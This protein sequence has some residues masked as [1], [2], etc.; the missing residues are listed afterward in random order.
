MSRCLIFGLLLISVI[1]AGCANKEDTSRLDA[2]IELTKKQISE[3]E[4][5]LKKYGEGAPLQALVALRLSLYKQTLAML[6][7]K[8]ASYL[9]YFKTS[10]QVNGNTYRPPQDLAERLPKIEENLKNARSELDTA[11]KKAAEARGLIAALAFLDAETKALTVAQLEY[12]L[13][14]YQNGFP[15]Y[16]AP[17]EGKIPEAEI[18]KYSA[19]SIDTPKQPELTATTPTKE[20][21]EEEM[22]KS[23]IDIRLLRKKYIP[24]DYRN[25][26]YDDVVSI[27]LEY[28]NKT[29]REIRAFTGLTVF[30]DIFDRPFYRVSLTVDNRIPPGKVVVDKGKVIKVNKFSSEDQQLAAK[31]IENIKFRFEPKS[32]LF[33]DG[34][35]LGTVGGQ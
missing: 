22:L 3:S 19:K 26:I 16:V 24:S 17:G 31:E 5:E 33:S 12:Q 29:D 18:A 25:G 8:R 6:E 10:Y 23:S 21:L 27:E 7:Q 9:F 30:S 28:E 11:K 14:A 32:I 35:C 15:P 20:Q 34:T 4:S 1:F 13:I 2:Q